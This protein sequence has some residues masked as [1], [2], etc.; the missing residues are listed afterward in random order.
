MNILILSNGAPGYFRFFNGLAATLQ[1]RG[2]RVTVAVDC[3]YSREINRLDTLG[4]AVHDFAHF[5]ADFTEAPDVVFAHYADVPLNA[6]LLSDFE[7]AEV[8]GVGGA[9]TTDYYRRLQA[10]LL[11]YF[12]QL[13]AQADTDIILYENV[14]N[15]FAHYAWIVAQ[16]MGVAYCGFVGSRLPGRFAIVSDPLGEHEIYMAIL[17][18]IRGGRRV[19]DPGVR[20]WCR[21][22]LA[23]L[24]QIVPD[25]MK[26]NNL[27]NLDLAGR[28][29]NRGKWE[30]LQLAWRHRRDDHVHAFQV[31]N[32]L[33]YS[34]RMVRRNLERKFRLR[35]VM[36]LYE[37]PREGEDFLLYPLHFH[38]E[39]STSVLAGTYLDEYEVIRNIAFNLP[40]GLTLYVKDHVSAYGYASRR[41]Y[42]RLA[43][44]PN[45]RLISPFANTKQ[46]IRA[47]Q[48]VITLTSTV[49]YEA[50]MLG[51]RV[52]LYGSVFYQGHPNVV[53]IENPAA[54]FDL[55]RDHI[56]APLSA[57]AAYNE[58]FLAAYYLG[59]HAGV[60][61]FSLDDARTANL[62]EQ[63]TPELLP[64][65]DA[66]VTSRKKGRGQ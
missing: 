47:S 6:A 5:F 63:I 35:S 42:R 29:V 46:L 31:G 27:D 20:A 15:A 60:L 9:R 16:R 7:R 56:G 65:L 18:D 1:A 61:N 34:W 19:V 32:P 59:T 62:I 51:R 4:V 38:P 49:G 66:M 8:Y 10:A 41:F 24:E 22:Y 36:P 45:V 17:A 2:D 43:A 28:Y 30:K 37:E 26:F 64:L 50:L 12:E 13:F 21:D 3:P 40:A 39:S 33:R 58:D 53:R 23:N 57:D 48:A 52:F 55:L 54:L 11:R 44:L 25:Y 14:S